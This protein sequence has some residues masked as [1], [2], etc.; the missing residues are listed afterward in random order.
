MHLRRATDR[1]DAER[2]AA[3]ENVGMHFLETLHGE[4]LM[5]KKQGFVCGSCG[6][7]PCSCAKREKEAEE[8]KKKKE[9]EKKKKDK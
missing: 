3:A 2:T 8:W 4:M 7:D 9:E 1:E 6:D 5:P